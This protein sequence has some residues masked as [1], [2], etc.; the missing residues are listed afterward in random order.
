MLLNADGTVKAEQK[1]SDLVGGLTGTLDDTDEFGVAVTGIGDLDDDGIHDLAVGAFRDDDGGTDRGAV[2]VLFLNADGTV[3]SEQKISSTVGG[4]SAT[5][6]DDDRIGRSVAGIGDVDGDGI[7]DL[8]VGAINDDDGGGAGSDRGAIHVLFLN[9]NGTVKS[10]QKISDTT[11]GLAAALDIDDRWGASAAGLGDLNGDGTID[12]AVGSNNDDDGGTDRGAVYVLNLTLANTAPTFSSLDG[13]PTFVEDGAAVVLDADVDASDAELDALNTGLGNYDGSSLNLARNGG[14]SAEDVFSFNDGNGIT[15]SGGNL[16]KNSQVIATFDITTTPGELAVT[17]T[18][19]NGE[20]PLSADVDNVLQQITYANSSN[21]PPASAQIDW[22]FDDGGALA[23]TGSTTVTITPTADTPSVTGASTTEETQTTSGLVISRNVSDGTEVTHFKI[24]NIQNG[25]LFQNNGTTAITNGDFITF[26]EG[27]AGLRFTPVMDFNG[28]ATFD[29]QASISNSDPGLGGSVVTATIT[30]NP[31]NDPPAAAADT[32]TVDEDQ[33]LVVDWWHT[34]WTARQQLSFENLDHGTL[35]DFP[36]LVV[37]NSGNIDYTKTQ[38]GGEDLRFLDADGTHLAYEIEGWDEDGDSHVWVRIPQIDGA[39]NTDYIW[40]YYG[41]A[42]AP[43]AQNPAVVWDSNHVGV[44]HLAEDQAGS[45]STGVYQDSTAN[46]NDG[47]DFVLATGQEGQIGP[48]Q[49]FSGSGDWIEVP[50]DPSLNLT[51]SMTISFWLKPTANTTTFNRIVEKGLWGYQTAYYFGL[52]DGS[53]D[54]TFYLNNTAVHDTADG[55]LTINAWQH[56]AVSYDSATGDATLFLNGNPIA[57]GNYTGPIAGNTSRL[58]ISHADPTYDFAGYIDEVQISNLARSDDWISAQHKA[59]KNAPGDVFVAFGGEELAPATGGLLANDSDVDGDALQVNTTPVMGPANGNLVLRADG[60]FTYTPDPAFFGLDT[61]TY[62]VSDGN[63]GTAQE[64]ASITVNPIADTPAVTGATTNEE[65]QSTSGLV[66]SRNVDDGAEVTHFKI[67]NILN[68]S[69]FQS[70]GTTAITAGDFITFA[71]GNTG[72]KFTPTM[73]FVGNA[74]F[75][76][77]ASISNSD[78]GLGGSVIT[79]TIAVNAAND[80]PALDDTRTPVLTDENEDAEPP[81]GA[82]GTLIS[83]LVDFASPAG[84]VD[85]V[86]DVDS[87]A[88]LGI[89]V[90]GAD[91]A[92]GSW[93]Y[94]IDGGTNWFAL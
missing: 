75:G 45:G 54:L 91:T 51:G 87:G 6:D 64:T 7:E 38:D 62:E 27:N 55:L 41:N 81:S 32:Y 70:N 65:T 36:V 13:A 31:Q 2:H 48:G 84:Q 59:T 66:I 20:I 11:G 46:A 90:T 72:L 30:V 61:F 69:L 8:A 16:I 49:Q 73:D 63:T 9:S 39:S 67:T 86:T 24:T 21:G 50:H 17:F 34:D 83:S 44:W 74:T 89:A 68:G 28:S 92:N 15:L 18:D 57:S 29:I 22:I 43:A 19:A 10:E 14:V 77:Q 53:N 85:N 52:G 47:T 82:V 60:T 93:H 79:A 5:L 1:I 3:K 88:Q 35:T 25:S 71:E 56:A 58:G 4:L 26:A 80:A 37:L 12:L 40:M 42:S 94:T 33:T 76:I 78:P 23:A